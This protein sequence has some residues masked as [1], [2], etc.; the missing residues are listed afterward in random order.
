MK[1]KGTFWVGLI[2][3]K[4][5]FYSSNYYNGVYHADLFLSKAAAKKCY[6]AV[7]KV[8]VKKVAVGGR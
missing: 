7:A 6:E 2:D 4:L 5:Y 8:K 1:K 3:N